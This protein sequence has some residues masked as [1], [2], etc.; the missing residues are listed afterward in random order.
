MNP[1]IEKMIAGY[2]RRSADD[3]LNALREILQELALLGLWRGRF[4]E[5]AAFYGGSAL[6][7][8]YGLSRFSEDMDFSLLG[9]NESFALDRYLPYVE[10]ELSAWGFNVS[11][12]EKRK[13]GDSAVESAFLKANTKELLLAIEAEGDTIAGVHPGQVLRI[14]IE[15]D[16]D[17]PPRFST[18]VKYCLQPIPFSVRVYTQPSLFAG[19]MHALLCR[20]W[21]GRVKGRDWYDFAWYV[22]GRTALDLRHLESRMRQSGHY[23]EDQPLTVARFQQ[24]LED[25]IADLDADQARS[26][27][28]RFVTDASSLN[29]WSKDF[30]RAVA[31]QVKFM[32][33]TAS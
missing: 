4:F 19:K 33:P 8:L 21:T 10:K 7:I 1:A 6:R 12:K 29:V 23:A 22:G 32:D 13:T 31:G 15:I 5:Q 25:R 26:D 2:P 17:P 14:K 11:V 18:E 16:T 20:G 27:V 28:V 24:I 9:P 30:F 3:T